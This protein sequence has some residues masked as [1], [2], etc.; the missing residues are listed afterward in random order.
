MIRDPAGRVARAVEDG[1]EDQN[2]LDDPVGLEGL[3]G[4]HAVIA[5]GRAQT[6][7]SDAEQSHAD[8][9][10]AWHREE[11]QPDDCEHVNE[12]DIS[13]AGLFAANGLPEGTAPGR[14]GR[15]ALP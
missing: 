2:L 5:D 3:V 13:E 6:A 14:S 15:H 1:P 4:E 12:D 10:E 9:L 11:D 8:N 7:K